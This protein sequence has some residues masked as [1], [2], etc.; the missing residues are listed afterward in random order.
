MTVG[1]QRHQRVRN[2][3]DCELPMRSHKESET[4][5]IIM[6]MRTD[7][8]GERK[9]ARFHDLTVQEFA[10]GFLSQIRQG[11][12]DEGVR[13][14]MYR[15]LEEIMRDAADF[16]WVN[17]RNYHGIL[18]SQMEMN[19]L[20]WADTAAIQE[21]R[22][23]YVHRAPALNM[24]LTSRNMTGRSYSV[25]RIKRAGAHTPKTNITLHVVQCTTCA[26]TVIDGRG[27]HIHIQNKNATVNNIVLAKVTKQKTPSGRAWIK[28]SHSS[29]P[30]YQSLCCRSI[31]GAPLL[32]LCCRFTHG[33]LRC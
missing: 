23:T 8:N 27:M 31:Q 11:S 14:K 13:T 28:L 10:Y 6:C 30:P 2:Q 32:R 18:M 7:A 17:V 1:K 19:R 12:D 4:G 25:C 15:H 29:H 20:T 21:L 9:G 3:V 24:S 5:P 22:V 16:P 33:A 26:P